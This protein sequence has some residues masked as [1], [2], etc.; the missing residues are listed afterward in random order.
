V[1]EKTK[2]VWD[3]KGE[4]SILSKDFKFKCYSGALRG[5]ALKGDLSKK[6]Q[7]NMYTRAVASKPQGPKDT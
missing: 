7:V 6:G 1:T 2:S 5:K 4:P 3:W